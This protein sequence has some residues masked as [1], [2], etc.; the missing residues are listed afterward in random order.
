MSKECEDEGVYPPVYSKYI[1]GSR[2]SRM[3]MYGEMSAHFV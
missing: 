3:L 2:S 1:K